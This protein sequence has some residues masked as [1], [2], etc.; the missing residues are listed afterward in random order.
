VNFRLKGGEKKHIK[1]RKRRTAEKE[2]M[3]IGKETKEAK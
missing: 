1:E 2:V 3:K